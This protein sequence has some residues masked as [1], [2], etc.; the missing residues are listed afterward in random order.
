MRRNVECIEEGAAALI[1]E[2]AE[3]PEVA[4]CLMGRLGIKREEKR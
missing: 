2:H 4:E 3:S 1:A